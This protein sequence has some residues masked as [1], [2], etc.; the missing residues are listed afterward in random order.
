MKKL[1]IY[2]NL[3]FK[4]QEQL[5]NIVSETLSGDSN[6]ETSVVMMNTVQLSMTVSAVLRQENMKIPR[7]VQARAIQVTL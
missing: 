2:T 4:M 6:L 7:M 5:E 3:D 1:K